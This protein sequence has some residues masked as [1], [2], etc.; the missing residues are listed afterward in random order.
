MANNPNNDPNN[1]HPGPND[2][3]IVFDEALKG[4]VRNLQKT[5]IEGLTEALV[6]IEQKMTAAGAST[7]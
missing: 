3:V 6:L 7:L 5:D 4:I 1:L 2:P